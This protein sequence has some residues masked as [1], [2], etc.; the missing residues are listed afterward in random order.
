M[1]KFTNHAKE[2]LRIRKI[3]T[4]EVEQIIRNP[5]RIFYDLLTGRY[6]AVGARPL[7]PGQYLVAVYTRTNTGELIVITVYVTTKVDKI[8]KS[9]LKKKRWIRI[10]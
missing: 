7:N 9:K 8:V 2:K 1:I 4:E 10:R 5:T 3:N 6:I